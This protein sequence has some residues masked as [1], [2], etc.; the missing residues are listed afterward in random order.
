M[1]GRT[2]PTQE[3]SDGVALRS[4][5]IVGRAVE[6]IEMSKAARKSTRPILVS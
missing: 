5:A 1:T 3:Y 4:S 6:T 2:V